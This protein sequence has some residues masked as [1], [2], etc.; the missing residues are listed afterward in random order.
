MG[1]VR[2][3]ICAW[4]VH[5]RQS[6]VNALATN[7]LSLPYSG[8]SPRSEKE[9]AKPH[10]EISNQQSITLHPASATLTF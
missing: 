7:T 9:D 5:S 10:A 8:V 6:I 2:W 4:G 1:D 3:K